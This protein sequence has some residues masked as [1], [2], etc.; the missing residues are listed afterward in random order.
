MTPCRFLS[1]PLSIFPRVGFWIGLLKGYT[2]GFAVTHHLNSHFS[3][4]LSLPEEIIFLLVS[5][6]AVGLLFALTG[7]FLAALLSFFLTERMAWSAAFGIF[8]ILSLFRMRY[9]Y[10]FDMERISFLLVGVVVLLA[11]LCGFGVGF[12]VW[13]LLEKSTRVERLRKRGDLVVFL[14][15][16]SL[17]GITVG[18]DAHAFYSKPVTHHASFPSKQKG[19]VI[20]IGID[21]ATWDLLDP[22]MKEGKLPHLA[23]LKEKGSFGVLYSVTE[24]PLISPLIWTTI[25]TGR[26]VSEHGIIG[27][28][29]GDVLVNRT[30]RRTKTIWNVLSDRGRRVGIIE[31]SVT[32]PVEKVNGYIV[33]ERGHVLYE[34]WERFFFKKQFKESMRQFTDIPFDPLVDNAV[35]EVYLRDRFTGEVGRWMMG[36][37]PPDFFA[38]YFDGTDVCQH[39]YL[40]LRQERWRRKSPFVEWAAVHFAPFVERY[41][42]YLD[43]K[44]GKLLE[45]SPKDTTVILVSDHGFDLNR[46]IKTYRGIPRAEHSPRGVFLI[47][48]PGVRRGHPIRGATVYDIFPTILYLMHEPIPK[49]IPGKILTD[50]LEKDFIQKHPPTFIDSYETHAFEKPKQIRSP[51]DREMT[52]RLRSLGYLR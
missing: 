9:F 29:M 14:L 18:V 34:K 49:D 27:W 19:S 7:L 23:Q 44:I 10:L 36:V 13:R 22:F 46:S 48:G 38:I 50:S 31:W 2:L 41:Y 42:Q 37:Y 20:L 52:E 30:M 1:S 28:N 16:G 21:G 33:S 6:L 51:L 8:L 5:S 12:V 43:G 25:A 17:F 35:E 47:S 24:V 32:W 26:K 40:M 45:K 11:V 4:S 3:F 15:I 39:R